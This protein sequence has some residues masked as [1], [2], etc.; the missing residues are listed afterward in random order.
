MHQIGQESS[1]D[2]LDDRLDDAGIKLD[3]RLEMMMFQ[4]HFRPG[5]IIIKGG[6]GGGGKL[7]V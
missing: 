6:G 3:D 1:S 5:I 7:D 2:R 4:A